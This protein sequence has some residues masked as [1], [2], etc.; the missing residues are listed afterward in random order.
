MRAKKHAAVCSSCR[1][2]R[3]SRYRA[4]VDDYLCEECY[5]SGL[6][7]QRAA[8]ALGGSVSNDAPSRR[9]APVE[10]YGELEQ[11]DLSHLVTK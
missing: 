11:F 9:V 1:H 3:R 4:L 6:R 10:D 7:A 5:N 2:Q 8:P